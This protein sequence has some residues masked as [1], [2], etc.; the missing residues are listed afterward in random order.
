MILDIEAQEAYTTG[1]YSRSIPSDL[2]QVLASDRATSP[3]YLA[4]EY[5]L[6]WGRMVMLNIGQLFLDW[7]LST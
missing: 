5:S 7:R 1:R 3:E 2:G 4:N 6:G